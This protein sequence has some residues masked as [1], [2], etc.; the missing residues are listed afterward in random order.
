MVNEK[1]FLYFDNSFGR[2]IS[3][4]IGLNDTIVEVPDTIN[5]IKI[6]E[7]GQG[8]FNSHKEIKEVIIPEG[9][10]IISNFAFAGCSNLEK[11]FLP[12]SIRRIGPYAIA[13]ND[14]PQHIVFNGTKK[15]WDAIISQNKELGDV[16]VNFSHQSKLSIFLNECRDKDA[17]EIR[18]E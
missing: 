18:K 11:I 12:E 14:S 5:G 8:V 2:I 9:I 4:Y 10:E 17:E 16:R 7:I 3:E 1:D 13:G 6:L 15:Q